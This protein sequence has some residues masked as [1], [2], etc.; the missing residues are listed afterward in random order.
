MA[1]FSL[2]MHEHSWNAELSALCLYF[3]RISTLFRLTSLLP[4]DLGRF[5]CWGFR[6]HCWG[7]NMAGCFFMVFYCGKLQVKT[8]RYEGMWFQF[9][10]FGIGDRVFVFNAQIT[11]HFIGIKTQPV[12]AVLPVITKNPTSLRTVTNVNTWWRRWH[13]STRN[14]GWRCRGL[15]FCWLVHK[16][17]SLCRLSI[18]AIV[19]W[20][21]F[22]FSTWSLGS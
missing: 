6:Q 11:V 13:R 14:W 5:N 22:P 19:V 18:V 16:L 2:P 8:A 15:S 3:L 12:S 20:C 21:R 17:W 7:F 9:W 1:C 10:Y 4:A